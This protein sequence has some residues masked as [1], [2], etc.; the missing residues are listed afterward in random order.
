M[1]KE[2]R[3]LIA[4]RTWKIGQQKFDF[5]LWE[6]PWAAYETWY[7]LKLEARPAWSRRWLKKWNWWLAWNGERLGRNHDAG[8]LETHQPEIYAWVVKVLA[9]KR[10]SPAAGHWRRGGPSSRKT[11]R[12]GD[13]VIER[14]VRK[15]RGLVLS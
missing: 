9:V 8:L 7:A 15:S 13:A 4:T 1:A 11:R 14:Y 6:R 2:P 12:Q 10:P 5:T 3:L